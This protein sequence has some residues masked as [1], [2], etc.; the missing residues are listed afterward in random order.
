MTNLATLAEARAVPLAARQFVALQVT[1]GL[2]DGSETPFGFRTSEAITL[3]AA[4]LDDAL[5]EVLTS[6]SVLHKDHV[7]IRETGHHRSRLYAGERLDRLHIYTIKRASTPRYTY[8]DHIPVREHDLYAVH[9]CTVDALAFNP[10][11]PRDGS[12][13]NKP[14]PVNR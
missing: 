4:T 8:R 9:V 10:S 11:T 12:V 2:N 1:P 14:L 5:A 3:T 13:P 7:L 6:R